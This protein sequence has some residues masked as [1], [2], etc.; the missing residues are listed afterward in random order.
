MKPALFL[1]ALLVA[2]AVLAGCLT[3]PQT[4]AKN[5]A[6]TAGLLPAASLRCQPLCDLQMTVS[7]KE[8]QG[9]EVTI[10]VNPK[11][12][13]NVVGGAKDYTPE[14]AGQCVW[15]GVYSTMDGGKTFT[16]K[17]M[18]GSPWV[19]TSNPNDFSPNFLSQYWCL[20][21]PSYRFG[22]DG[23]LY[24]AVMAY[25]G[26]P[27]TGSSL[28]NGVSPTGGINDF[29]FN[30]VT[31]AIA[32][33]HDGGKTFDTITP[34]DS[35]TFPI[36]FHDR[37]W[38]A[39]G[40]NGVV[41]DAWT[42]GQTEGNLFYRS[43]DG[44]KSFSTTPIFL[45]GPAG[46]AVD[47]NGTNSGPADTPGGLFIT[48]GPKDEVAVS[49]CSGEGPMVT[50]STDAG[51]SFTPWILAA[52]AQDKGMKAPFRAGMTCMSA[53]DASNGPYARSLYVVWSDTR[54]G[55]RDIYFTVS[56]DLGKTWA[57]A[58]RV[59]QDTTK[60]D[61]FFPAVGVSPNG[62]V[63]IAFMDRQYSN[64]TFNDVSYTYSTD[65]GTTWGKE[66]RVTKASSDPRYSHH[67]S[68]AIFI[69]DYMDIA[70]GTDCAW[71]VWV[72]TS[73]H[74]KADVMTACVQRGSP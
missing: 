54:N 27:V 39:A 37:E 73:Q 58:V 38:V 71:P 43:T 33:S 64:N 24:A 49:G 47:V 8:R 31:Q 18:P 32:I 52:K 35:G 65:G 36:D 28:G 11:D 26:D 62:T 2:S 30:R 48:T 51:Q 59:N 23:T 66:I 46:V 10:A 5:P 44:G 19:L 57:P 74:Q 29:A 72:D 20:T 21:D 17:N 67:Q 45:D 53:M 1:A 61:Q 60:A 22:P 15:D 40:K 25:Q 68:G 50:F 14:S 6:T 12:P 42:T 41:Y 55:D 16:S 34:V 3:P 69:G 9:N 13:M 4:A 7:P 70:S 63:D 56:R